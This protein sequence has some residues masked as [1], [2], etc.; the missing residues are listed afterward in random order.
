MH[1]T[2][3]H[4]FPGMA[5]DV[6]PAFTLYDDGTVIYRPG[7]TAMWGPGGRGGG[8][9]TARMNAEQT[10]SLLRFALGPGGLSEARESYTDV[11]M[12]DGI[13]TNFVVNALGVSKEVA[14][15][16]LG[17]EFDPTP[18]M[19]DRERFK[20]VADT[21]GS[22][23]DQ[24]DRGNAVA[25]GPYEPPAYKV[26]LV[27]DEFGEI[28]PS[29]RWP[30]PELAPEDFADDRSGFGIGVITPE[31]AEPMFGLSVADI[32]DPV[33]LG[34]DGVIYLIRYR[35]LMPDEVE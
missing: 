29:D 12:A 13:T 5:L 24:I 9:R 23:D 35:P 16:A 21:L 2:G 34:P 22:F 28:Q 27:P 7:A 20:I 11:G 33:V 31:E 1:Q 30:W 15:Y 32:G 4:L 18:E 8:L 14:V 17:D 25:T 19:A 10:E 6:A 26:T 3:G